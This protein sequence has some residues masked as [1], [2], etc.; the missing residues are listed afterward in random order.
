LVDETTHQGEV[1][2][3]RLSPNAVRGTDLSGI[4]SILWSRRY[5]LPHRHHPFRPGFPRPE[6]R[7]HSSRLFVQP[8]IMAW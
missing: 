7:V 1:A 4:W 2:L 8:T 6:I 3:H 5:R